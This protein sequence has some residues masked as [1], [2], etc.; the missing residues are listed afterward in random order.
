MFVNMQGV[1]TRRCMDD[2]AWSSLNTSNCSRQIFAEINNN[3]SLSISF[4]VSGWLVY[5]LAT[6]N[7]P[8]VTEKLQSDWLFYLPKK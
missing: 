7:L 6:I 2:G 4:S 3:V 8:T 5:V 1:A